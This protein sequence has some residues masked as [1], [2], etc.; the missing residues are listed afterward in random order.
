[1][2]R[3]KEVT[4]AMPDLEGGEITL[5]LDFNAVARA[6]EAT[7][8][9]L[10]SGNADHQMTGAELRAVVHACAAAYDEARGREPRFKLAEIGRAMGVEEAGNCLAAVHQLM[11]GNIAAPEEMNTAMAATGPEEEGP[12]DA[13]A[14][15]E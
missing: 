6:E 14:E 3:T 2:A 4:V 10:L 5:R 11:T 12:T 1:M 7:K 13:P 15:E 9:N 8:L